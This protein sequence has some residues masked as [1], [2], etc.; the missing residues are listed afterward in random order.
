[1]LDMIYDNN[2][3]YGDDFLIIICNIQRWWY[4]QN[5]CDYYDSDA[6]LET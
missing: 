4:F 3:C 5:I 6:L 2:D 1:M